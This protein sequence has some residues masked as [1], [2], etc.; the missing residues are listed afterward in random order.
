[1]ETN[2]NSFD[3]IINIHVEAANNAGIPGTGEVLKKLNESRERLYKK[4][5]ELTKAL[6]SLSLQVLSSADEPAP[7]E[8]ING[9]RQ[10]LTQGDLT[11]FTKTN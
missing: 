11:A 8:L 3:V 1:M 2:S 4:N 9:V 6:R 10:L 7:K 5:E